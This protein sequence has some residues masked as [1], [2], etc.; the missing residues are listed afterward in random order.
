[1]EIKDRPDIQL[2]KQAVKGRWPVRDATRIKVVES[3]EKII[4]KDPTCLKEY[5]LQL[6]ACR[7]LVSIDSLNLKDEELRQPKHVIHTNLTVSELKEQ[8]E[9]K[10]QNLGLAGATTTDIQ[11]LLE[12]KK[13]GTI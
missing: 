11:K 2:V 3:I 7:T 10:L 13:E 1:M 5:E 8:I 6:L 4:E 9:S 12:R